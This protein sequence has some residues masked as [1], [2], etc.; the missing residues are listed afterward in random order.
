MASTNP[1]KAFALC[2]RRSFAAPREKVF[3]AWTEAAAVKQWFI[4]ASEGRWTE[5]PQLDPR[6]GGQYRF[7]GVSGAKA[8]CVHGTYREVKPPERLVFT[9]LWEDYP[10]PGESGD[11]LVTVEFLDRGAQTEIV[12]TH[13]QLPNEAARADHAG[14]WEG[15]FDA[16]AR[17]LAS[18]EARR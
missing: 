11:T 2:A 15:C 4:E 17:L 16:I 14:G 13:E 8:W 12:L 3:K 18:F 6:P 5:E 9:W 10:N 1:A 7:A